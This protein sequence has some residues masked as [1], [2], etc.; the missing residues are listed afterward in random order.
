MADAPAVLTTINLSDDEKREL[1]RLRMQLLQKDRRNKLRSA[2]YEGKKRLDRLGISIP[3][4]MRDLEI[5]V[6][7]PAKAV[8]VLEQ[9]LEFEGFALPGS[10]AFLS[11]LALIDEQN[12]MQLERSQA[13]VSALE[14][15]TAFV[16][17]TKGDE[18]EGD[19]PVVISIRSAREATAIKDRRRRRLTS[20]LE[21]IE[22]TGRNEKWF[23]LHNPGE[24]ITIDASGGNWRVE[25]RV[26]N[27]M[28]R[29]PCVPLVHRPLLERKFGTSRITRPVMS[30]TDIAVR[31]LFRTEVSA[32]FYSFP[33]RYALGA[34]E[35][36]FT[37]KDGKVRTGWETIIGAM[38]AI[39]HPE[40]DDETDERPPEI[41][42]GQFPQQTMTPHTEQL[43]STATLFSGE[44]AIPVSYLGIIHDNPASADAINAGESELVN[45]AER[46]HTSFGTSWAEVGQMSIM[47][48]DDLEA[49]PDELIGLRSKWRNASTPTK[50][51]AAQSTMSLVSVGTFLPRSEITFEQL[52]L[53]QTTVE[54]LVAENRRVEADQARRELLAAAV[55]TQGN[56]E[57]DEAVATNGQA[58]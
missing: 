8:D 10:D 53:D 44:T 33:Q 51:A 17:V 38:L 37:D 27:P 45:V 46:D 12:K 41:R 1:G 11:D 6:G 32:E 30:L 35:E 3:P 14:H 50:Q 21:V 39:P 26:K 48:R 28:N 54:R 7:W 57:I 40:P 25:D 24:S 29:V 23:I 52:G 13:H 16:F 19:P 31:T 5:V 47:V 4:D 36:Q 42:V 15:G 20:A 43:R 9:R 55:G 58:A 18:S 2:Y 56:P 49:V 34:G 22:N